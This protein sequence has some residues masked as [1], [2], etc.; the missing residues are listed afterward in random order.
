MATSTRR[1]FFLGTLGV[2][3]AGLATAWFSRCSI[4][5]WGMKQQNNA[6][7]QLTPAPAT[8][9]ELCLL[10]SKQAEGPF[11]FPSPERKDIREDRN[12]K[13]MNLR[14]QLLRHPNCTPVEGAVVEVWHTDADGVYSGYPAEVAHDIWKTFMFVGKHGEKRNGEY[15]VEPVEETRFL[16]GLQRTDADGWVEFNTIFPGW[17][18]GRVP[19][20]HFKV[21]IGEQESLNSQFYL[22]QA[23]CEHIYTTVSP[24]DK[25]GKCP[26]SFENDI[27]LKDAANGLLLKPAWANDAPMEAVA[28]IG[29]KSV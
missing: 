12:S 21:F 5:R 4:L 2:L 15:H 24:Y 18:E 13:P 26:L 19:H 27:V 20:I 9:N 8:E 28:R 11:Y 6:T 17:Y 14:M 3:G 23:T 1:K 22:E 7:L 16:R 10:T 25:Y 29:I